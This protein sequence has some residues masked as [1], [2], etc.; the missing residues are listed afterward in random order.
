MPPN[1]EVAQKMFPNQP[2]DAVNQ[3][4]RRHARPLAS[5]AGAAGRAG[6]VSRRRP[7][8]APLALRALLPAAAL[9]L[10]VVVAGPARAQAPEQV[11]HTWKR[12][13]YGTLDGKESL[14]FG[15]H[16]DRAKPALGDMDGDGDLDLLV[17]TGAGRVMYF[18]N[19][20]TPQAPRWRLVNESISARREGARGEEG[21]LEPIAVGANAAPVLVDIDGDGDLDLFV[22]SAEGKLW[23]FSNQG[24]RFLPSFRLERRDFLNHPLGLNL[25]AKFPDLNGDGLPDLSLGNEAGEFFI[26]LN[27]G[28]RGEPRYCLGAETS[29]QCL[30]VLEKL[31]RLE[32]EDNAVPEWVDW[33]GDG[34]LDLLVG[35]S[36]GTVAYYRNIGTAREGSW[37]L[38]APRFQI[39]DAGGFAAPVLADVTGDG[40][41]DLLLAG[42]SE[43]AALYVRHPADNNL[44]LWVEDKNVLQVRRLGG[45]QTRLHVAAGDLDGDGD[46]ELVVGGRSGRLLVYENVGTAE[47]PAFRSPAAPLLPTPQRSFSAPALVD[48]DGDGDLDLIVGGREGRLEWIENAGTPQAA[49]WKARSLFFARVDVGALSVPLF[50]DLDG[51][52]DPDLLVGNSLGHLVWYEN[53]GSAKVPAF[54]LRSVQFAGMRVPGNASP[55]LF[56]WNDAEG[57]EL[58]VGSQAGTLIPVV[59]DPA[60]KVS[61]QGAFRPQSPWLGGLRTRSYSAPLFADLG[62]DGRMDLLLGTGAGG[63]LAWRYEGTLTPAMIAQASRP[64]PS[65]V[66]DARVATVA[67]PSRSGLEGGVPAAPGAAAPAPGAAVPQGPLPLDPILSRQPSSLE[68]LAAGRGSKPAFFDHNGD[69]RPDLLLGTR[70]G[71]LIL[72]ES[73]GPR[74]HPAWQPVTERFAGYDGGRNAAPVLADVDGDGDLD[75]AVGN[76][77]GQVLYWENTGSNAR[78]VFTRNDA[79]FAAVRAGNNAV[80]AFQDIDGDGRMD[81]LV[82]N[83]KGE[84]LYYR[85][86]A[87]SP[88]AFEL[89]MRRFIGLDVGVN[90]SPTFADLTRLN[91]DF[92]LVGSDQ[93]AVRVFVPTGTSPLRSSGWKEHG[94]YLEGL[95]FPPGSHPVWVDL[96]GDGDL[97]LVVGSDA[98]PLLYFR[99]DARQQPAQASAG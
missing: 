23:F 5:P 17:G 82:G 31:G 73:T 21:P 14:L 9:A 86:G 38:A 2:R 65:N 20:G 70:E 66:V 75:L 49:Q 94:G 27:Q 39:L 11:V 98:G 74:D 67:P 91:K 61:E 32:P 64:R 43:Q 1:K 62:G 54:V 92:L 68:K 19:Q 88:P 48:V 99:N 76:E 42:D 84:L 83:L 87:G 29:P 15:E 79:L 60:S 59:R 13:Y 8:L 85:Q 34:D 46:L 12:L 95:A 51:D 69:G 97:D 56:R 89:V 90:A 10:S 81:L 22:G 78:P 16:F 72:F 71:R 25:V 40:A 35:K 7:S 37:E 52:G 47:A 18:E 96:D 4:P 28:S 77:R 3:P 24:N 57:A 58:V 45:F 55:G 36:D 93:G 80:P 63:L 53:T 44:P 26:A 41:A 6:N 30:T 33:D 50:S